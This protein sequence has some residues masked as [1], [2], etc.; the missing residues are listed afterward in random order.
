MAQA[1]T[2]VRP[3][4]VIRRIGDSNDR[5]MAYVLAPDPQLSRLS[6]KVR[7]SIIA[8]LPP[9]TAGALLGPAALARHFVA[10]AASGRYRD[11]FALWELFRQRPDECRP[12]L[13]ERQKALEKGRMALGTA[14][15]LGLSGRAERVARDVRD[16]QGLIWTWLREVLDEEQNAV[17]ARPAIASAWLHREPDVDLPLPD[18]PD[19]RWLAEA[20]EARREGPLAPPVERLLAENAGRL[21]ATIAT[22]SLAFDH[23]PDQA[24]GLVSRIDLDSP[25][26]GA[27]LAWAR[28]HGLGDQVAGRVRAT[29]EEAAGR[30]RAEGVAAWYSWRE[31]GVD[32][33]L[34]AALRSADLDGLDVSRPDTAALAA[35]LI[36]DGA[37]L[38]MQAVVADLAGRNRQL[39]EKAYEAYVCAGLAV[40]LPAGLANNPLVKE[41]TRCPWC[42]SWT[43]VRAGHERRCPRRPEG[44]PVAEA[45]AEPAAPQP[46]ASPEAD[47]VT[48]AWDAAAAA[49]SSTAPTNG[50]PHL[51]AA[52]GAAAEQPAPAPA[53]AALDAIAAATANAPT[54]GA[55]PAAEE[56]APAPA[57]TAP[58]AATATAAAAPTGTPDEVPV[59]GVADEVAAAGAPTEAG[60]APVVGGPEAP[61]PDEDPLPVQV[62][63]LP[64]A[65]AGADDASAALGAAVTG[66]GGEGTV[67]AEDGTSGPGA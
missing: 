2:N 9:V 66:A 27:L 43:Y 10:S 26:I 24:P 48:A 54:G 64:D 21:P 6:R 5:A 51:P 39:A 45:P 20:A 14:V 63:A 41:G 50:A 33:P 29:V 60:S 32:V 58:A 59:T 35:A 52:N 49:E 28:D 44:E 16:A 42:Q 13:A 22:L 40:T 61:S 36:A 53:P 37:P 67:P 7:E 38:D 25:Q 46:A 47:A 56:T 31:R 17:A 55:A 23:Y 8:D 65:D 19:D 15:R 18:D 4:D 57:A 11:L 3:E 30:S 34:P 62:P 12:V 1:T